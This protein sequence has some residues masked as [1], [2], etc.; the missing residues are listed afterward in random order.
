MV[1]IGWA[2][3]FQLVWE[4]RKRDTDPPQFCFAKAEP[5]VT[6]YYPYIWDEF[7]GAYADQPDM[8]RGVGENSA[9]QPL[10]R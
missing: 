10:R 8:P 3:D 7:W 9:E 5:R 1:A 2:Q 4:A 6:C